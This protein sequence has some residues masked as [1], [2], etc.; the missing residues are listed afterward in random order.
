MTAGTSSENECKWVYRLCPQGIIIFYDLWNWSYDQKD[1]LMFI[2]LS[3]DILQGFVIEDEPSSYHLGL[4]WCGIDFERTGCLMAHAVLNDIP[5]ART[6]K[7]FIRP[8]AMVVEK[9][10]T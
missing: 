10:T 9:L 1:E 7:G 5:V 6:S 4:S 2:F 3:D 8:V